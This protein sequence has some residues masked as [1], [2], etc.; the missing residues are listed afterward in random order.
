MKP[1]NQHK[2]REVFRQVPEKKLMIVNI[3][4]DKLHYWEA[5]LGNINE[6]SNLDQCVLLEMLASNPIHKTKSVTV[7]RQWSDNWQTA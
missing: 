1:D 2:D 3:S 4:N 6:L 7:N 5:L